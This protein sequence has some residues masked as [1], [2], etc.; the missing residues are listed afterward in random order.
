MENV[1]LEIVN[2]DKFNP[3]HDRKITVWFRMNNDFFQDQKL[4]NLTD[5][6]RLTFVFLLCEASKHQSGS[7]KANLDLIAVFRKS[8][9][10]KILKEIKELEAV[11]VLSPPNCGLS[12]HSVHQTAD[13][14]PATE[15]YRTEQTVHDRTE[16]TEQYI[17][18]SNFDFAE[19]YSLFPRKEGKQR[20]LEICRRSIKTLDDFTALRSSVIRYRDHLAKEGTELRFIK[21]FST[22]M[23]SWKDWLDPET[24]TGSNISKPN[25]WDL[26]KQRD[27]RAKP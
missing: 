15:Q 19:I 20:G 27:Q 12:P 17:A 3:R 2:W 4:W 14:V 13:S 21:Q 11:G 26:L 22:F 8:S 10:Q 25:K 24:G 18:Q 5:G 23:G 6:A 16:Q 1:E 7:I 9:I